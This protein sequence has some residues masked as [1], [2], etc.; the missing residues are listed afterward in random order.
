MSKNKCKA[1]EYEAY[2][3]KYGLYL[4]KQL[5]N[6][7]DDIFMCLP[8]L[9]NQFDRYLN[10]EYQYQFIYNGLNVYIDRQFKIYQAELIGTQQLPLDVRIKL[11]Q[12]KL[13]EVSKQFVQLSLF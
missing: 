1:S 4:Y 12:K 8:F 13:K 9:P 7:F 10:Q 2:N 6:L 5:H 11:H 3:H